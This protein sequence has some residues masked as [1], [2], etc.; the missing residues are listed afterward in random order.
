MEQL[1]NKHIYGMFFKDNRKID[2]MLKDIMFISSFSV[3]LNIVMYSI[4]YKNNKYDANKVLQ[5]LGI[6]NYR[7]KIVKNCS[8]EIKE[9]LVIAIRILKGSKYVMLKEPINHLDE[10]GSIE[11]RNV[12][13]EIHYKYKLPI[14]IC[15]SNMKEINFICDKLIDKN[16]LNIQK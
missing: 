9:K 13:K 8:L 3:Y 7:K 1:D 6:Y 10:Q 14:V 15:S 5:M 4:I 2:N 16:E 12:I 11:I